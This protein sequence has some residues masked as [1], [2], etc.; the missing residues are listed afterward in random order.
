LSIFF[1]CFKSDIVVQSKIN[2]KPH[3]QRVAEL[4]KERILLGTYA[5]K[6]LPSDRQ[7]ALECGVNYMT[8][9]R[10][11]QLLID[12]GLLIRQTNGRVRVTRITQGNKP[13]LN[14][15]YLVP[16][17]ASPHAELWRLALEAETAKLN[18]TLRTILYVHWHDPMLMDCIS[19][20][21]GVFLAP[22]NEPMPPEIAERLRQPE[23]PVVVVDQDHSHLG[24]PTIKLFPT[25][26]AQRLLDHLVSSGRKRIA[27]FN[28]QPE[29]QEVQERIDQWKLWTAVH[30]HQGPLICDP[31]ES[32]QP[33]LPHA[34]QVMKKQ[35]K[36]KHFEADALYC[37]TLQAAIGAMRALWDHGIEPGEEIAVCAING[38]GMAPLLKPTLTALEF[39]DPT[40]FVTFC[41]KWMADGGKKWTWPLLMQPAEA[42][43][44]LG[45]S[46]RPM[47]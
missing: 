24:L 11:L 6:P 1:K 7:L 27:C 38:E 30:H 25:S 45:E 2:G 16:T 9:R 10:G 26:S 39:S 41:L 22:E 13:C 47:N 34:Y 35:L 15:A 17:I 37:V 40:P 29:I 42:P 46:T 43:L 21:D 8:V 36:S 19:G 44:Y 14:I 5:L 28:V 3:F 32:H 23:H 31:V 12:Q 4:V 20:F 33:A 18:G